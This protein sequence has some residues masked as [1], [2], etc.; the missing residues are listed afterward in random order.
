MKLGEC[1]FRAVVLQR[2]SEK[3]TRL[4]FARAVSLFCSLT[5]LFDGVL[6]D[7]A[8]VVFLN[9]LMFY[10]ERKAFKL[11]NTLTDSKLVTK[12]YSFIVTFKLRLWD[13]SN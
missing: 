9:S 6:H 1:S 3:P 2:T 5:L 11:R 7:V 8:V 13:N 12:S 10:V 4:Y